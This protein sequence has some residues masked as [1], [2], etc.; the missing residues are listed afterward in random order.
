MMKSEENACVLS[1]QAFTARTA[2]TQGRW[3]PSWGRRCL[4]TVTWLLFLMSEPST[5]PFIIVLSTRPRAP[6][7]GTTQVLLHTHPHDAA[8]FQNKHFS[9][10][11]L[12]CGLFLYEDHYFVDFNSMFSLFVPSG[13]GALPRASS[14]CDTLP[15]QRSSY[16][17]ANLGLYADSYRLSGEPVFSHRH[18]G[19]VDRVTTRTPS[20]ES[21]HKDPRYWHLYSRNP[22]H[23]LLACLSTLTCSFLARICK[24]ES[25]VIK[26]S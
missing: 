18:S 15:Y 6:S 14:H 21:I 24:K 11:T 4:Q 19:L 8:I 22:A 20:I 26:S 12:S 7:T 16:G 13:I 2:L 5:A 25:I 9:G 23:K 17:M 1:P 10:L 3:I